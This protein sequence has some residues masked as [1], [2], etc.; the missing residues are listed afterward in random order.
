MSFLGKQ[1]VLAD[2]EEGFAWCSRREQD[3]SVA[4][5]GN[6]SLSLG[7]PLPSP[8]PRLAELSCFSVVAAVLGIGWQRCA[9]PADRQVPLLVS[10][11][12]RA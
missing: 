2:G 3:Q 11:C 10:R 1:V 5:E 4:A 8:G 6:P 7:D 12:F 9:H